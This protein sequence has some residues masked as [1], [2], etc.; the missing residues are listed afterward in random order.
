MKRDNWVA[1]LRSI[2]LFST[3]EKIFTVFNLL[4]GVVFRQSRSEI[5][6]ESAKEVNEFNEID[7]FNSRGKHSHSRSVCC[8]VWVKGVGVYCFPKNTEKNQF[9]ALLRDG[10]V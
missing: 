9:N 8:D 10:C 3:S 4:F 2:E 7:I 1:K 5:E 6:E